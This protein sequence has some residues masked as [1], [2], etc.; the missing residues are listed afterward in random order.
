MARE[1]RN[2]LLQIRYRVEYGGINRRVGF[3]FLFRASAIRCKPGCSR[4][5]VG[6]LSVRDK[7]EVDKPLEH[8]RRIAAVVEGGNVLGRTASFESGIT[9]LPAS[10]IVTEPDG[11]ILFAVDRIAYLAAISPGDGWVYAS[12]R[13]IAEQCRVGQF[14]VGEDDKTGWFRSA[15]PLR[16]GGKGYERSVFARRKPSGGLGVGTALHTGHKVDDRAPLAR[17]EVVAQRFLS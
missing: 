8:H 1:K 12:P 16:L 6:Y 10:G 15:C 14:A 7:I 2:G 17:P 9:Q 13:E 3:A 11:E 5:G 4:L